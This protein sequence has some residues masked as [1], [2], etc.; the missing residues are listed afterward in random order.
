MGG[1]QRRAGTG[2]V[3]DSLA[4]ELRDPVLATADE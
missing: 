1:V 2:A 4:L 3:A